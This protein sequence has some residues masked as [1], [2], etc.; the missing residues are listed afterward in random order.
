M[1]TDYDVIV[2]GGGFTGVAAAIAASREGAKALIV[3]R[4]GFLGGAA[5]NS[6]V[7][8]FMPYFTEI[9]GERQLVNA[10]LFKTMIHR[11][12]ELC[13]MSEDLST[14]N[15][16][17]LKL[18]LDR[19]VR[20][21]NVDVLFHSY[22]ID[23]KRE[24]NEVKSIVIA[25]KSG[26]T[27]LSAKYFIDATGDADLAALLRCPFT[28]GRDSDNLCQPMTLCFR[29]GNIDMEKFKAVRND[30]NTLYKQFRAEGK[31]KNPRQDV[32]LFPHMLDG[33]LH[34][35]TTRIIK[36]N[37]L[38]ALDITAAEM[39]AREQVY[40]L[41]LFLKN[42]IQG[43]ENSI[44]LMSAPQIGV[45][46]SRKIEGEYKISADELMSC[47]KFT[48]SIARGNY[49]IDIHN[50]EGTGTKRTHVPEGD[51][52]TIPYRA[53][54][55][56]GMLNL[57]VAGRCISSTHEAQ[58][59]YRIMPICCCIGEGAGVAVGVALKD[60]VPTRDVS[61]KKVRGLLKQYGAL[62]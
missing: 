30:I 20:E 48:D 36:K 2:V 9:N 28:L 50:P 1:K 45:R 53:L 26:K 62:I 24:G 11:L 39:D 14:F 7:N 3:E 40:E 25:N 60:N 42:N 8:P 16:E 54:V 22:M 46:E 5:T 51:Y 21:N 52:Y 57:L 19:M 6:L 17:I 29:I 35:N 13:G 41:Y 61:V 58:S 43:F 4:Y 37:P 15:E 32:L 56:K 38:N 49:G 44:L 12:H 33:V 55:P 59:A 31:I 10:G 47:K 27:T 23:A 18:V 34:F